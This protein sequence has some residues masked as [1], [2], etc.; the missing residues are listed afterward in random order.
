MCEEGP[1]PFYGFVVNPHSFSQTVENLF[2]LSFLVR[3]GIVYISES[4]EEGREGLLMIGKLDRNIL[5]LLPRQ[6]YLLT[7][8]LLHSLL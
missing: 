4:E 5:T 2:Y 8:S 6:L 3:D 7:L 1:I